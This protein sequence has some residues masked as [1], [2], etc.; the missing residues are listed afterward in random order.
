V[1]PMLS[2]EEASERILSN[3]MRLPAEHIALEQALGRALADDIYTAEDIPHFANSSMDGYAVRAEDVAHASPETPVALTVVMDIP[4]GA[5]PDGTLQSGQAARIMTG[6]ALPA[7]ADT[8]IPVE[9]S[10]TEWKQGDAVPLAATIHITKPFKQG[11]SVRPIGEDVR[12][13]QLILAAGT[14]IRASEMG[15]LAGLGQAH[16]HVVRQPRVAIIS[17]GDELLEIDQPLSLGKIRDM[18]SYILRSLVTQYGGIPIVIPTASDTLADIRLRLNEAIAHQPDLILSS[19]GVS[20]GTADLIRT[21]LE[22]L[23]SIGFWRINLRPGKPLAYGHLQN[24]PFLGLPGNPVSAMVTFDVFVRP[25]LLKFGGTRDTTPIIHATLAED[26]P[27]DGRRSY[28]RVTLKREDGRFIASTTGTQSSGAIMSMVLAD[29]L[30]IIPEN[31]MLALA[32][33]TY[34]VR[35]LRTIE[36]M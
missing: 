24:I 13:G 19:A 18:N 7:G 11:A 17:S 2:V 14:I 5:A 20:V 22:E 26:V 10:G 21:V 30:M 27:S 15:I 3:V 34:P 6:A 9:Q 35:L 23:G 16:I 32:G 1:P 25:M 31:I 12:T 29:G 28:I 8:V 36:Y 33:E 4:A